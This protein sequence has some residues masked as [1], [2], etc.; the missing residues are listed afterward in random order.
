RAARAGGRGLLRRRRALGELLGSDP[1][2]FP[3]GDELFART[4]ERLAVPAAPAP[5]RPQ[6][7]DPGHQVE[8]R[9]P[10]VAKRPRPVLELPVP[11]RVVMRDQALMRDVVLVDADVLV[12]EVEDAQFLALQIRKPDLD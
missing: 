10:D 8:L 4:R 2:L 7:G 9:R 11:L 3:D 1:G 5:A 12:A 6:A